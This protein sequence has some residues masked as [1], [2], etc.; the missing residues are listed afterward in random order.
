MDGIDAERPAGNTPP[1]RLQ[2]CAVTGSKHTLQ[3]STEDLEPNEKAFCCTEADRA[4]MVSRAQAVYEVYLKGGTTCR[5]QRAMFAASL[6]SG[7]HSF[8]PQPQ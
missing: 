6:V 5:N 8:D 1:P 3:G 7:S 2:R 4:P